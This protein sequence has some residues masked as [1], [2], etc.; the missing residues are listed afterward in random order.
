M[1]LKM[2]SVIRHFNVINIL[3]Q[4]FMMILLQIRL[5]CRAHRLKIIPVYFKHSEYGNN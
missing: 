2:I 5:K 4:N 3:H 1:I